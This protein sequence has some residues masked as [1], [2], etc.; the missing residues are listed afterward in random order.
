VSHT[1]PSDEPQHFMPLRVVSTGICCSVGNDT[2]A[3]SAAIRVDFDHF[4]PGDFMD[5]TGQPINLAMLYEVPVWG[6]A[7]L[8]YMYRLALGECLA[9]LSLSDDQPL[10][11][12]ILIGAERERGVRFHRD[13]VYLLSS[14]RPEE[15]Y[16]PRTILG[17]LG[18]AGIAD[19]LIGANQMFA[20]ESPPEYVIVVGVDSFLDGASISHFL[21]QERILC[22]TNLD[23]FIPGEAAAAIALTL[24]PSDKPALWIEGVGTAHETASP[25]DS[26][27][28]LRAIGLTQALRSAIQNAGRNAEDFLFHASAVSGEQWYFKEA[29]LAMDRTMTRK[30]TDFPHRIVAQ[31]VGEIGAAFG[32]LMLSWIGDEMK[33]HDYNLGSRGLLHFANDNGQRAALAVHHH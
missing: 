18:K 23:G 30:M 14:N 11:P 31:S 21:A 33:P 19:A 17:C 3:A 28:P 25:L 10:P 8:Q 13:M 12:I 16:D 4:R 32:P 27:I 6:Q 22:S 15:G 2:A 7:R 9:G 24:Q 29:A 1:A 26:S 20:G 5:K